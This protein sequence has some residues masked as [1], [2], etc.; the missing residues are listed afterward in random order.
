[1][2]VSSAV[3][4][5]IVAI[6]FLAAAG[7]TTVPA[8]PAPAGTSA[9]AGAAAPPGQAP[10]GSLAGLALSPADLPPHYTLAA[11]RPKNESEMSK[12]AL[13]LGWQGGYF[14]EY[15]NDSATPQG[16]TVIDQTVAVYPV[17]NIPDIAAMI[18]GQERSDTAVSYA[19]IP[20]PGIGNASGGYVATPPAQLVV[21][22]QASSVIGSNPLAPAAPAKAVFK[23]EIAELWFA[24]GGILEI[25]RMTGPG[26]DAATVTSLAR[27]AYARIP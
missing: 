13:G 12:L 4:S 6:A 20:S 25:I 26:A 21:V 24:K 11:S 3:L 17:Q 14:V 8:S 18:S 16:Q 27:A 22:T 2:Q 7:C 19:D 9:P 1:M 15:T 10:S 5:L 23:E